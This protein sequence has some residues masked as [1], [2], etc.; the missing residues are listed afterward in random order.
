MIE[1]DRFI[2]RVNLT[3]GWLAEFA[4]MIQELVDFRLATYAARISPSHTSVTPINAYADRVELPYFSN[5]K[6]ACGHF[7]TA[8]PGLPEYRRLQIGFGKLDRERH[9]I[10]RA[11]GHSMDGGKSPI[12]DGDY[13]LCEVIS[14]SGVSKLTGEILAIERQDEA[15]DNQYLL[16]KV[17]KD[18][19][20]QYTLRANNPDYAD[21][22]VTDELR[23][24]FRTFAKLV[25]VLD[26]LTMVIGQRFMREEIATLFGHEF[27]PGSWN[28]GHIVLRDP[29]AHILLVTLNK[30]GKAAEHRFLDRWVDERHFHWQTQNQTSPESS[31]GEAIMQQELTGLPIHLFVR[32]NKLELGKAAPFTYHGRVRYQAHIGSQPMSIDFELID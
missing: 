1:Q 29:S 24:Q 31:R 12:R 17:L 32:E 21:I 5:L 16:R 10:A 3:E 20:G 27:N 25:K 11:A 26:P 19:S 23:E 14:A 6:I 30:Q 13:L 9:F 4:E 28:S 2:A 22:L 7:R 8:S 18:S 15:G